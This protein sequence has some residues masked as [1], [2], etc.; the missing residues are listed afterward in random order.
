LE[1]KKVGDRMSYN[2]TFEKEGYFSKLITYNTEIEKLG[3]IILN[4]TLVKFDSGMKLNTLF[5]L[6]TI[7][8]DLGSWAIRADAAKELDKVVAGMMKNPTITIELGSHTDCRGN[9]QSNLEL[10]DKRAKSS[11]AYIVSKGIDPSRITG[12]GYGESKLMNDCACE[13]VV[14][15]SCSEN[16]HQ[17]NRRTEFILISY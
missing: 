1:K 7:Y 13:G 16:E 12:K 3:E 6:N 17:F 11:A 15:S 10:S 2:I 9:V 5:D 14:R 8:F 4:E